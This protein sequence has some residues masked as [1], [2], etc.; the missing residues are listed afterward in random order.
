MASIRNAL[1]FPEVASQMR[2]LFGP[3][4]SAARQ[5][6]LV[7]ADMHAASEGADFEAWAAYRKAKKGK[8]KVNGGED[9]SKPGGE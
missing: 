2:R 9:R 1:A 4:G 3:H 6:V 5:D 8:K 7:A